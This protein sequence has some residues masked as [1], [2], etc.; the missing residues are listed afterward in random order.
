MG[1]RKAVTKKLAIRYKRAT[2]ADKS[3]V[4]DELV[5][6]TGW[7]RDYA[8]AALR[9]ALTLR[10]VVARAPRATGRRAEHVRWR[11]AGDARR[12]PQRGQMRRTRRARGAVRCAGREG[13]GRGQMRRTRR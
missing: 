3:A 11:G 13:E 2:R 6:L 12:L 1:E 10:P 4:L 8:R 7:H 9:D 5:G